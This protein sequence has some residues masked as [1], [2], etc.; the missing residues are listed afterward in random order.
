VNKITKQEENIYNSFLRAYRQGQPFKYRKDFSDLSPT[1][2]LS[3][4]KLSAFFNKFKHISPDMFFNAPNILHP[5]ERPQPINFFITRAAIKTYSLAMKKQEDES[6]E[7][8]IDKIKDGLHFIAMFCLKNKIGLENYISFKIGNMPIWMQHYREH[9]INPYCLME[10][11]NVSKFKN[12]SEDERILWTNDFFEKFD[13][14][15]TRYHNS[16]K[17]KSIVREAT[18][19]IQEFLNKELHSQ[20]K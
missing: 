14:F 12:L 15:K 19:K 17:T 4:K 6:P 18:K 10:L 13:S 2:I 9:S 5:N 3:L 1:T 11:G 8:Q 16:P 20:K 7:K